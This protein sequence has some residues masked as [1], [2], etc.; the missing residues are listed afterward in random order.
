MYSGRRFLR[1][2]LSYAAVVPDTSP[3]FI[4]IQNARLKCLRSRV[5]PRDIVYCPRQKQEE[6][7]SILQHG[8]AQVVQL[9]E[10][11][12]ASPYDTLLDGTTL[13]N[14]GNYIA[15]NRPLAD[16]PKHALQLMLEMIND[17][18]IDP[19]QLAHSWRSSLPWVQV[20]LV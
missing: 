17:K 5:F 20:D 19:R 10:D 13:L 8:S 12:S 6:A 4:A 7:I 2:R 18:Q 1:N 9:F 14:V 11:G 16:G 15:E 3:A